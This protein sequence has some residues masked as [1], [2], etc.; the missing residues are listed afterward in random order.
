M[1]PLP[2]HQLLAEQ[3]P[4]VDVGSWTVS[5]FPLG[6]DQHT[7]AEGHGWEKECMS[8]WLFRGS[9]VEIQG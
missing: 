4:E 8:T 2:T 9:P 7:Q 1:H 5:P 3:G 6:G